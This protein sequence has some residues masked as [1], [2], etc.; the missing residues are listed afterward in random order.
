MPWERWVASS[1]AGEPDISNGMKA[2]AV[3]AQWEAAGAWDASIP[4]A[5]PPA[6]EIP[7]GVT[8]ADA[9]E[10]Y[11]AKSKNRGIELATFNKYRTFVKQLRA[12]GEARGYVLIGQLTVSDMD[13]FYACSMPVERTEGAPKRKSWSA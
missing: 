1:T 12:Y 8:I 9:T 5:E 2:R 6:P 13:R 11:L 10:S 4:P 7:R 3:A